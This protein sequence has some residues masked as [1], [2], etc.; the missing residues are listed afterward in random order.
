[1]VKLRELGEVEEH[2]GSKTVEQAI[3]LL[4]GADVAIADMYES[5]LNAKLFSS[6]PSVKFMSI[7]STGFDRVDL[8]AAKENGVMVANAP[9]FGT[10][11][12]AE[13]T[14]ALILALA[15]HV[16]DSNT[17]MQEQPFEYNPGVKEHWR[18]H[19]TNISGKTLGIIGM[20]NIGTRI[21]E[22]A[23]VLGMKVIAYNRNPKHIPGVRM[24]SLEQLFKES[25][26]ISIN[27]A[28]TK[29]QE[30]L[31]N[32]QT[33]ALMKPTAFLINTARSGFVN[34]EA[35]AKAIKESR[36]AGAGLDFMRDWSRDSPLVGSGRTYPT[37]TVKSSVRVLR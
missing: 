24:D 7:N 26:F 36:L 20:G 2:L 21:A 3:E 18:Y 13:H 25:D 29:D 34:D 35:L 17:A 11:A 30:D 37:R 33:L 8:H 4:K 16:V 32:E 22:L 27:A 15:H 14:I 10:Q 12:V 6:I 1:M 31:I 23:N 5:P 28:F 19:G 9:N